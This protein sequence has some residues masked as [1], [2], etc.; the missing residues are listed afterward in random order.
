MAERLKVKSG[1]MVKVETLRGAITGPVSV[2]DGIQED[3]IFIPHTFGNKQ[4]V[5]EDIGRKAWDTVNILTEHY[6][7]TLSGQ[8][9]YKAQLCNITKV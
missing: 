9:E 2:W 6:Y 5:H 4:K 7:D 3:T 1:D 8:N